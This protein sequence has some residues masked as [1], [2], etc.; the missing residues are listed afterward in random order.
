MS[1]AIRAS[2]V[3]LLTG[4]ALCACNNATGG[5]GGGGGGGGGAGASAATRAA[6]RQRADEVYLRQN[7]ADIY[8][9]DYYV[10]STR[11]APF[12]STGL[13][14]VSSDGL[15]SRFGREKMLDDCVSGAAGNVGA[16]PDAP[17][18]ARPAPPTP[19]RQPT[20]PPARP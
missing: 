4:L 13:P 12:A 14:G 3:L 18:P 2:A 19:A 1:H 11:D 5:S 15:S 8:R 10:G 7:R 6:C 9:N 17:D 16:A 20:R